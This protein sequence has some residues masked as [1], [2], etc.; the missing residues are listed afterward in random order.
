MVNQQ[1]KKETTSTL[2]MASV[3]Y[4]SWISKSFISMSTAM[5]LMSEIAVRTVFSSSNV[6][7]CSFKVAELC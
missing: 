2:Y 3:L 5:F 7:G 6:V 4:L 1:E